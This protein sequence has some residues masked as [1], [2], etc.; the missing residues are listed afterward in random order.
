MSFNV[1]EMFRGMEKA[2]MSQGGQY[3]KGEGKFLCL[4]KGFKVSD[5]HNGKF[6][7]FEFEVLESTSPDDPV[8]C[9]R[10]KS[11]KWVESNK[12]KYSDA[13]AILFALLGKDPKR[14]PSPEADPK[15]HL[16]V[17]Q[18]LGAALDPAYAAKIN[19]SPDDLIDIPIGLT[20][21][22]KTK[23]DGGPFTMHD[24]YPSEQPA[25]GG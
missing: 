1:E 23:R 20:T 10:S 4:S 17:T 9:T 24:W 13:K 21:W 5:G 8:G 19:M 16:H 6:L 11:I 14:V 15:L 18:L 2:T 12:Y 7:H 3:V 25:A 22:K